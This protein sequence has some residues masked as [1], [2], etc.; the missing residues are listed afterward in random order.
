MFPAS[1]IK[2]EAAKIGSESN[3]FHESIRSRHEGGEKFRGARGIRTDRV[4]VP[5]SNGAKDLVSD[6]Q[7]GLQTLARL[8]K[9][10]KHE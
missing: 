4:E 1:R 10:K 5:W 6:R 9:G 8:Q 7:T 2:V 3:A